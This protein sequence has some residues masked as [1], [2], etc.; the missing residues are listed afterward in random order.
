MK[1]ILLVDDDDDARRS[2]RRVLE[3]SYEVHE[4]RDGRLGFE[5]FREVSPDLVVCDLV[6]P[7]VEGI[8]LI[9]KLVAARPSVRIIAVSGSPHASGG[10]Y[11]EMAAVLGATRVLPKPFD[12]HTLLD[13]VRELVG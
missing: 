8:E 10:H 12:A 2:M 6:M 3:S 9:R 13:T 7:D 5:R 11:L 1:T 4:A